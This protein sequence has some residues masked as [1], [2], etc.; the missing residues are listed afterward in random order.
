MGNFFKVNLVK[1]KQ[2]KSVLV[3]APVTKAEKDIYEN[4]LSPLSKLS[5]LQDLSSDQ[6]KEKALLQADVIISWN[7]KNELFDGGLQI[8]HQSKAQLLQTVSAGI[9]HL[10]FDF[11]SSKLKIA[12]NSGAY[13]EPIAEHV[14]AMILALIKNILPRHLE[15]A[16]GQFNQKTLNRQL[17]QSSALVIGMGGIGTATARLLSEIGVKVSGVNRT[18]ESN[19]EFL[20]EMFP[21]DQLLKALSQNDI[22]VMA[23]PLTKVTK[24]LI[25][26]KE[27]QAMKDDAVFINVARAAIVNQQ[28]LFNHLQSHPNF[29]VGI[30]TW[31]VEPFQQQK[32]E[33]EFP[34]F[35]LENVLGS[36]HNSAI[37]K[38]SLVNATSQA[39][40]NIVAYLEGKDIKGEITN[41]EYRL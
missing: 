29:K 34:F 2:L 19:L 17:R 27:L 38:D 10:P 3:I 23:L 8:L 20:H 32:F 31:W 24:N 28:D 36:P 4:K 1:G 26:A 25:G 12:T 39:V 6:E 41:D 5:F 22:I 35:Q 11:L 15:L 30:D 16:K 18:G 37:I 14:L 33:L 21:F 9:D 7:P 40:L 13:S